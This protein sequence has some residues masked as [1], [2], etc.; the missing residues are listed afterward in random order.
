MSIKKCQQLIRKLNVILSRNHKTLGLLVFLCSIVAAILELLGVSVIAPLISTLIDPEKVIENTIV[1]GVINRVGFI[2]DDNIIILIIIA[3]IIVYILKNM[4]FVFN[5]WIKNKYSFKVQREVSIAM[6]RKYIM[7]GYPFFLQHNYSEL[8]QGIDGDVRSLYH[9]VNNILQ[10]ASQ[11]MIIIAITAYM[12]YMD[13]KLAMGA[14]ITGLV[15]LLLI[16]GVFRRIMT[17]SGR[18][19][20]ALSVKAEKTLEETLHGIKLVMITHKEEFF[21]DRYNRE[22]IGRNNSDLKRTIGSEIPA[23]IIEAVSITGIMLSLIIRMATMDDPKRFVAVLGSFA[24]GMFRILPA[25]GKT[26]SSINGII[27]CVP[28]LESIYSN[29]TAETPV[30]DDISEAIIYVEDREFTDGIELKNVSFR[31]SEG[32]ECVISNLDMTIKKGSSVAIV[33]ES[34][35]GKSTLVDMILGLLRPISGEILIDGINQR[36]L[37]K[38]WWKRMGYV[39]QTIFLTDSSI[40]ENVAYGVPEKD[41]NIDKVRYALERA[42]ILDFVD[43]LPMGI[44]TLVG[45]RGVRLSGGQRQRIGIAR[46]LYYEPDILVLDEATSALDNDTETAVMSAIE[47]LMG[48]ITLIVVAHRLTT[49]KNCEYI[50]EIKNGKSC[51]RKYDELI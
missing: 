4:F 1:R 35:A 11:V 6:M 40:V 26:S 20:R 41:I 34:G 46:A 30:A 48:E 5:T 25:I 3:V 13:W 49:I 9:I 2:S 7:R 39:P 24:I 36:R 28:G 16:L 51:I 12:V 18:K 17:D 31:Y 37:P 21:I 50:Y 33:G 10:I 23:Y 29:L 38:E 45:D 43:G 19:L 27:S 8:R 44:N 47:S 15:C 14:I 32:T 22:I 42:K